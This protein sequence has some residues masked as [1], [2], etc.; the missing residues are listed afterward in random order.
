MPT[1]CEVADDS[2]VV[3]K[4]R[5]EK[6]GNRVEEKTATTSDPVLA[7]GGLPKAFRRCE[8]MKF[9][10]S[11]SREMKTDNV[12]HK[13]RSL[14]QEP[15]KR[16]PVTRL[17]WIG[18]LMRSSQ[19]SLCRRLPAWDNTRHATVKWTHAL[20]WEIDEKHARHRR[21]EQTLLQLV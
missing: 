15:S 11:V 12:Q 18:P 4:S 21:N 9:Q 5:P 13:W 10:G 14:F 3:S 16:Y 8:G 7:G 19:I 6:P 1:R 2:V 20:L 17:C